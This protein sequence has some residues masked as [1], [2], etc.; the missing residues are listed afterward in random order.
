L[1]LGSQ[2]DGSSTYQNSTDQYKREPNS[3]ADFN[4]GPKIV[5]DHER[6]ELVFHRDWP[7]RLHAQLSVWK[8]AGIR[9]SDVDLEICAW[10][11]PKD[12]PEVSR[13]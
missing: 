6:D 10:R 7:Q 4:R 13:L 1:L 9:D 5:L 11:R 3:S 12:K 8:S 2:L